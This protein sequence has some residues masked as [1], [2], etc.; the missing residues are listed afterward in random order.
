MGEMLTPMQLLWVN[1][2]SD[3]MP[4]IG[5]SLE[6][7]DGEVMRQLPR[8]AG[9]SI[10]GRTHVGLL[11]AEAG[12]IAAGALASSLY[13]A[14]RRGPGSPQA[15]TI[16][17]GSL[18]TA[19]LLHALT[20]R[21]VS[22][23]TDSD[24]RA[25]RSAVPAI[26]GGSLV[27]QSAAMLLPSLRGLLGVAP[28]DFFESL[29]MAAGGILPFIINSAR[30][31]GPA[32]ASAALHFRCT[33]PEELARRTEGGEAALTLLPRRATAAGLGVSGMASDS[34]TAAATSPRRRLERSTR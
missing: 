4:A 28:L 25:S 11:G 15:C 19:Q 9:E 22:P 21:S 23:N 3:V 14:I 5:L 30:G 17:F 34:G 26:V 7:P 29:A 1:L 8:P 24:R 10:L 20:Y 6:P 16:A 32:Q 27:V 2:V 18:V 12:V 13:G 31:A 33:R